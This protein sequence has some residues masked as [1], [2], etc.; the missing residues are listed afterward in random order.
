MKIEVSFETEVLNLTESNVKE[1]ILPYVNEL[2]EKLINNKCT[3]I[4]INTKVKMMSDKEVQARI[5]LEDF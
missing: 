3:N 5:T 1:K 2:V 4:R